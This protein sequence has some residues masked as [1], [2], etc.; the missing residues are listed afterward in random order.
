MKKKKTTLKHHGIPGQRWGVRRFQ[1]EDGS[2]TDRG[3]E[4]YSDS[5]T[6]QYDV[7]DGYD[8][9]YTL[10]K[11]SSITRRTSANKDSDFSDSKYT[12]GYD[13]DN[14]RDDSFYQQFGRK[15]TEYSLN[16]TAK[17]AGKMTLGKAFAQKMLTL[18]DENDI[19]A[20]DTILNDNS[21]TRNLLK[22]YTKDIFT[23]PFEPSKH[24]DAMEKIG[25]NMVANMLG[26]QRHEAADAKLKRRG[27]RDSDTAAN[28]IGRSIVEKLLES[29]YSGMRDYHDHDSAAGVQTPTIIFDPETK[30]RKLNSWIDD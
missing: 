12:F 28:D 16:D 1:N 10:P 6:N 8:G 29:G 19:D 11:G 7:E 2:L 5:L 3:Q 9:D 25:A 4:R 24:M 13:Y 26:A 22:G 14:G 20:M 15:I 27:F 23:M 18:T 17:L 21:A 30:L